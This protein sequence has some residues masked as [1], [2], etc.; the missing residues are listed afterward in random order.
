MAIETTLTAAKAWAPDRT[1]AAREVLP[2]ALILQ[3]SD[4]DRAV[5]GDNQRALVSYINDDTAQIVAEGDVIPESDPD[6][7]QIE[8]QTHK[9]AKLYPISNE[10]YAQEGAPAA[11]SEA[12][13]S[14]IIR[15]ANQVYLSNVSAPVGLVNYPNITVQATA[16]SANLDPLIDTVATVESLGA[17]PTH[18]IVNP[19]TW[20]KMLK[21][22]T[23]TGSAE[24]LLGAGTS[25]A[26]RQLLGLPVVVSEFMTAN[27]GLVIDQMA[28]KSIV[29]D[30]ATSVSKDYLFN[31]DAVA[32]RATFRFGFGIVRPSRIAKF[33]VA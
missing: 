10:L 25:A 24:G 21:I 30:V 27:T 9:V 22:K 13:R 14:A 11:L 2:E 31:R 18:L 1:F 32:L 28:I 8:F 19:L 17:R 20:A 15:E 33:T 6:M 29:S 12:I 4:V 16:V 5:L 7:N 26:Q 23:Q 3:T